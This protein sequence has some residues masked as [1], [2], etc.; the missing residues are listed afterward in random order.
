M[1]KSNSDID[2][3]ILS[4]L[5]RNQER[6]QSQSKLGKHRAK[7]FGELALSHKVATHKSKQYEQRQLLSSLDPQELAVVS[8]LGGTLSPLRAPASVQQSPIIHRG[9]ASE[10]QLRNDSKVGRDD[11]LS[12]MEGVYQGGRGTG[13]SK[14]SH[15]MY[16]EKKRMCN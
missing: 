4:S 8:S 12:Y 7:Y 1:D 15:D 14:L 13:M 6:I 2:F 5:R 11:D 10:N 9:Y 16:I 3:H